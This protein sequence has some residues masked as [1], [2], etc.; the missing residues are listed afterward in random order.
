MQARRFAVALAVGL[1]GAS[2]ITAQAQSNAVPPG[3]AP[4]QTA[5]A[6][7][8]PAVPGGPNAT[9]APS[10]GAVRSKLPPTIAGAVDTILVYDED[11]VNSLAATAATNVSPLGTTVAGFSNFNTLLGGGWD[12]VVVDCPN[13]QPSGG[14]GPLI[15]Y[16]NGG[17]RV[18][19]S[20]W[21]WDA[22]ASLSSAFDVSVS[23]SFSLTSP[24]TLFLSDSDT[25]PAFVGVTMPNGDWNNNFN[26][27][28]DE[29][30]PL[31][32]AFGI[33]HVG[34]SSTPAMVLGNN[35]LTIASFVIDEAGPTWL[36]DGSAVQL[37][38][39]LIRMV[40]NVGTGGPDIL[41]YDTD[42]VHQFALAAAFALSPGGTRRANFSDFNSLLF[43]QTWDTVLVDC[44]NA[45]PSGGWGSLINYVTNLDGHVAMAF[46]DWDDSSTAGDPALP[47]AFE[48]SVANSISM[49]GQTLFDSGGHDV[50]AGV[51]MPNS[52]WN[53]TFIDDGDEFNP[54]GLAFEIAHIGNPT[55]PVMVQGNAGRTIAS[56][57]IDEAG[58]TW[59][60][61]GSAVQLWTNL[62]DR[63]TQPSASCAFRNGVL[64]LNP[65][66]LTCSTEPVLGE[67]FVAN[68]STTPTMG[69][70]SL[71]TFV[72]FG[73]GGPVQ[74][75]PLFGHELLILP[76]YLET[77][78]LGAHNIPLPADP[79]ALGLPAYIQGAR[80]EGSGGGG[81]FIVLTNAQDLVFGF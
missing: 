66:D 2:L 43:S 54:L 34:S 63:V 64:G 32:G 24:S 41:V 72:T 80:L 47:G 6:A 7:P 20:F 57:V 35:G 15:N 17:G 38:E 60:N 13:T 58:D 39:N 26:D 70:F 56:F 28:G 5:K 53:D 4:H 1:S 79:S 67:T 31:G 55:T 61:D 73:F 18:V 71:T 81:F 46:W 10:A 42:T 22:E 33:G 50:F 8:A 68:V 12:V 44:P 75:I 65:F 21:N 23:S 30:I 37:W 45:A 49:T 48:V 11:T 74:G 36:G 9:G 25:S 27:D 16:V 62:I 69:T 51:T 40:G 19:A 59:I 14:W 77:T 29:F 78:S 3:T 76:P 52:D